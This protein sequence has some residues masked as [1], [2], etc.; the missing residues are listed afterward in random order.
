MSYPGHSFEGGVLTLCRSAVGVFYSPTWLSNWATGA[1]GSE[2]ILITGRNQSISLASW[3]FAND[4]RDRC[5]ISGRIIPKT[6]KMG[7]DASLV[8]T[9][10]YKVP[11]KGKVGQYREISSSFLLHLGVVANEKGAF[12]S[13]STTNANFTFFFRWDT[14]SDQVQVLCTS[15]VTSYQRLLKMVLDTSFLNSQQYKVRIM[16][17]VEQSWERSSAPP[18]NS[19][20]LL[21]I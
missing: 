15:Q 14:P 3:E 19:P 21:T 17:K 10:H 1:R 12:G 7:L 11:I 9:Q 2:Q 16:G 13:P 6:P 20:S 4:P 5:S 8:N 18:Y